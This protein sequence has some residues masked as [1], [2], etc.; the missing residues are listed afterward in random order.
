MRGKFKSFILLMTCYQSRAN[1]SK[2]E[3]DAQGGEY[4]FDKHTETTVYFSHC[5]LLLLYHNN[6]SWDA[7]GSLCV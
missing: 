5:G 6:A 4:C 7:R 3:Q 2:K 1:N